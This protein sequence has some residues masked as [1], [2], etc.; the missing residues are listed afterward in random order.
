MNDYK[1]LKTFE[2]ESLNLCIEFR[3]LDNKYVAHK[4]F[5]NGRFVF[6][7][8]L[9]SYEHSFFRECHMCYVD[10]LKLNGINVY[11]VLE[12]DEI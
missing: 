12:N 4:I 7:R 10:F 11:E 3:V 2:N 6:L 5:R 9:N 1:Y 8:A